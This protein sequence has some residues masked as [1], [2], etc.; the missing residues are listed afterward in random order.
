VLLLTAAGYRGDRGAA[1]VNNR[2]PDIPLTIGPLVITKGVP[3]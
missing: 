1:V 3:M 2:E